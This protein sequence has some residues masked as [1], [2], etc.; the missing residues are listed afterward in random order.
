MKNHLKPLAD[1]LLP[2]GYAVVGFEE[3]TMTLRAGNGM[4]VKFELLKMSPL[5]AS[6]SEGD[7]WAVR[8]IADLLRGHPA[9]TFI[10]EPEGDIPWKVEFKE[11][12]VVNAAV[13]RSALFG[14]R[15]K[16]EAVL[17]GRSGEH[18]M[19][20]EKDPEATTKPKRGKK[21]F[22]PYVSPEEEPER[23]KAYRRARREGEGRS[24]T[25]ARKGTYSTEGQED[26]EGPLCPAKPERPES[27][28]RKKKRPDVSP[29]PKPPESVGIKKHKKR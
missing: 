20:P 6:L 3:K 1:A 18:T 8:Q 19:G 16:F 10:R 11:S 25:I 2:Y 9:F 12:A 24:T 5:T 15:P 14:T 17:P 4:D 22:V 23:E 21:P 13:V 26:Q 7:E 29:C 27:G 28:K